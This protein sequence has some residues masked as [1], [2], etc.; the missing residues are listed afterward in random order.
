M[1][2]DRMSFKD[3]LE[4]F[5]RYYHL[6]EKNPEYQP[7]ELL[8]IAA[9]SH[10]LGSSNEVTGQIEKINKLLADSSIMT[11][12][13]WLIG[14]GFPDGFRSWKLS[15]ASRERCH[16]LYNKLLSFFQGEGSW[17]LHN[18]FGNI[19]LNRVPLPQQIIDFYGACS[20]IWGTIDDEI[21]STSTFTG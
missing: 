21:L 4:V 16:K 20:V 12:F 3:A 1:T 15:P 8:K 9:L 6:W 11:E 18:L 7:A 2:T 13:R 5:K 19:R 17:H 14:M 10:R